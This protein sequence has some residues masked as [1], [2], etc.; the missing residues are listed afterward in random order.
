MFI[1]GTV[2]HSLDTESV[3]ESSMYIPSQNMSGLN[4]IAGFSRL[5]LYMVNCDQK[6]SNA[7]KV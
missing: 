5:S 3:I 7:G 2:A 4:P 6:L 1:V